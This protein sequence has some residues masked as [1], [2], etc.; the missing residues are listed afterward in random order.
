MAARA[1]RRATRAQVVSSTPGSN[2]EAWQTC[3]VR[4]DAGRAF[5]RSHTPGR[6]LEALSRL[7]ATCQRLLKP[8]QWTSSSR[9]RQHS[10]RRRR[11]TGSDQYIQHI[12]ANMPCPL[13]R[14]LLDVPPPTVPH[15][16]LSVRRRTGRQEHERSWPFADEAHDVRD[17]LKKETPQNGAADAHN[18]FDRQRGAADEYAD[19]DGAGLMHWPEGKLFCWRSS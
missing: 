8:S 10:R 16:V 19:A 12:M 14:S 9:R 4:S 2:P 6:F 1:R 7:P 13:A 18:A 3:A 11:G 17:L 5:F 15:A